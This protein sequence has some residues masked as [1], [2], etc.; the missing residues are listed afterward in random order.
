MVYSR[1]N[2]TMKCRPLIVLC[3]LAMLV[4]LGGSVAAEP[5]PLI[6]V[7]ENGNGTLDFGDGNVR[8]LPVAI[9]PDPGPGG[10]N[11]V[12]TYNLLGPPALVAGDVLM[13]D[14]I[15]GFVLDVVRFNPAGTGG[16]PNYP[17]SLLFYS[18]NVDGFDSPADTPSP[19]HAFYTN[20]VTI[21]EV[22]LSPG[23]EGAMY[24]PNDG[25]PG[26]VPG[27]AVSY[28]LVSDIPEPST[29]LVA[30]TGAGLGLVVAAARRRR[31]ATI[32]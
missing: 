29:L 25:Q 23:V 8:P 31:K 11:A 15:G 10:L 3:T 14:G 21:Q 20:T 2:S 1:R 19:P 26:F 5:F 9:Q 18:D 27:F 22:L 7:D 24:T 12:M 13:Q 17:A 16:N 32:A 30:G 28:V 6:T 4:L